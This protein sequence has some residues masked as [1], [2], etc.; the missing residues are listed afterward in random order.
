MEEIGP[1]AAEL[2]SGAVQSP[3][4]ERRKVTAAG[5]VA[6]RSDCIP[7]RRRSG[8][9]ARVVRRTKSKPADPFLGERDLQ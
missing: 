9:G 2:D 1:R 7:G 5:C 6:S 4:L 8:G 3:A